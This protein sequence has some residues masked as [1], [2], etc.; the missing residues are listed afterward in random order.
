MPEESEKDI[1]NSMRRTLED[2]KAI[3]IL[4]NQNKLEE[5]KK[6]LLKEGSIKQQIYNIC[7]GTKTTK[8]LAAAFQKDMGYVNS[9]LSILRREGLIRTVEKEGKQ[10]HEQV[11]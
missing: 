2:I 1:L 11:F 6:Q 9:Y 8:D 3:F 10:V 5:A 4:I 7:D